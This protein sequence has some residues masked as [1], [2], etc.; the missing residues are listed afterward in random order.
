MNEEYRKFGHYEVGTETGTG[1]ATHC[2]ICGEDVLI[3]EYEARGVC[4]KVCDEC[5]R[6]MKYAKRLMEND[7]DVLQRA[8]RK[9]IKERQ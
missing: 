2:L 3:S 1:I 4:I 6:A 9:V 7:G 8:V 5:K